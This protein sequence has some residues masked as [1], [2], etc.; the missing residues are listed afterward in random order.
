MYTTLGDVYIIY[1]EGWV[2]ILLDP[3]PP[4]KALMHNPKQKASHKIARGFQGTVI[5]LLT[6]QSDR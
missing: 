5:S 4:P 2:R 1:E 6:E 3:P